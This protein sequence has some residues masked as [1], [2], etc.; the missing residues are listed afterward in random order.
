[1][2]PRAVAILRVLI[3]RYDPKSNIPLAQFLSKEEFKQIKDY[4]ITSSNLHPI[5]QQPHS[6]LSSI[7]Y[8]WIE[9]LLSHFPEVLQPS[10]S[11]AIGLSN[12]L[13]KTLENASPI[14]PLAK[15]FFLT[16]L[17]RLL[18][19]GSHLPI[20][21][22]PP[23]P[24]TRLTEWKKSDIVHLIDYL[25]LHDLASEIRPIVNSNA[26]KKIYT[27]LTPKQFHHLKTCL[28]KKEQLTFPPLKIDLSTIE[29]KELKQL[30]HKRGLVRFSRSFSGEH[31]DLIW[32][33]AHILDIGRGKIF[34]KEV[35]LSKD[36]KVT[37]ILQQ[38]LIYL[39][40][41]LHTNNL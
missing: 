10:V 33:I 9:S 37:H 34:V 13:D 16:E 7:H 35:A 3:N 29:I 30:L 19:M 40:N 28:H 15:S 24:L 23:S 14:S 2:D 22:L 8:S 1:M 6:S 18:D 11:A 41:F 25:G 36:K 5:L 12:K 4:S 39:M 26:L 27:S 31:P 17:Y 20:E 32:H 38:Q 21:Y